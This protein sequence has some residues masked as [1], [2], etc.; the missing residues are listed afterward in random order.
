MLDLLHLVLEG[1]K[2][3]IQDILVDTGFDGEIAIPIDYAILA[4]IENFS[5]EKVE[6]GNGQIQDVNTSDGQIMLSDSSFNVK[7]TWLEDCDEVLIGSGFLA[8]FCKEFQIDFFK[9]VLSLEF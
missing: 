6:Y 5:T 3:R 2:F 1:Q 8:K 9:A 7:I 4:K